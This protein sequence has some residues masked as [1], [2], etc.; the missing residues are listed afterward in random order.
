MA[1]TKRIRKRAMD[2]LHGSFRQRELSDQGLQFK[3]AM[4][5]HRLNGPMEPRRHLS[6][7]RSLSGARG[8]S[9]VEPISVAL[10]QKCKDIAQGFPSKDISLAS[11]DERV[12]SIG[13][14]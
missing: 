10:H 6:D 13:K 8:S 9:D 1:F 4:T 7:Q 3:T 14:A 12:R 2:E 5:G 11:G